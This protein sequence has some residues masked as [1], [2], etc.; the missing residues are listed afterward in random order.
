MHVQA[1][2]QHQVGWRVCAML[3]HMH[4]NACA[5]TRTHACTHAHTHSCTHTHTHTHKRTHLSMTT[6]YKG[7]SSG[8]NEFIPHSC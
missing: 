5:S 1:R 3:T 6:R 7:I 2:M 8:N 4:A